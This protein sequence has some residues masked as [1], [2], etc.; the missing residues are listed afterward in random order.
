[1]PW[2]RRKERSGRDSKFKRDYVVSLRPTDGIEVGSLQ[3][4]MIIN[5]VT[6]KTRPRLEVEPLPH[7]GA[8]SDSHGVATH[9]PP[10]RRP[11]PFNVE[12]NDYN[13]HAVCRACKKNG[14]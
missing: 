6:L 3:V 5:L 2:D 4:A 13:Q 1:M 8:R 11:L 9:L 12:E 7:S 10:S 14:L